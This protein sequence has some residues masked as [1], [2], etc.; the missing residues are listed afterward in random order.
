MLL[1]LV[2]LFSFQ[3][4]YGYLY[5]EVS[6]LIS[7]F[8]AGLALGAAISAKMIKSTSVDHG[9]QQN[10]QKL[11]GVQLGIFAYSGVFLLLLKSE[12]PL[13]AFA[14]SLFALMGGCLAGMAFP[15]AVALLF[16][17]PGENAGKLYGADLLGGCAGAF[18][19]VIFLIPLLGIPQ[20]CLV[21]MLVSIAGV[22]IL[23]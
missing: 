10:K 5:A 23:L 18:I 7:A 14:F 11:I 12:I 2:I 6:L 22:T 13:P 20:T 21:V 8:M 1:Q 17:T 15:L 4:L 3:V 19:G 9:G 16:D